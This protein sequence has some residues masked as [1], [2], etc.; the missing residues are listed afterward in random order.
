MI[1]TLVIGAFVGL[2]LGTF[3]TVLVIVVSSIIAFVQETRIDIPGVYS[4][5]ADDSAGSAGLSFLPNFAGIALL[6]IAISLGC[7]VLAAFARTR[8]AVR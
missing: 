2:A 3:A 8:A 7:V 4:V 5:W 1:K 6:V